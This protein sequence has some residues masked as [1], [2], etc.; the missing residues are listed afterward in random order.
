MANIR[1]NTESLQELLNMANN[2]PVAPDS[3]DATATAEYIIQDKTAYVN[4]KE[5]RGTMPIHSGGTIIPTSSIRTIVSAGTYIKNDLIVGDINFLPENIK[6]GINVLGTLGTLKDSF[7]DYVEGGVVVISNNDA[8][9][10]RTGTF[11]Y[12][13]IT[14]AN[15]PNCIDIQSSA[16]YNCSSL[17]AIGFPKCENISSM[18][19][20]SC[21][22]LSMVSFPKCTAI[23][24]YAFQSCTALTSAYFPKCITINGYSA[25]A[26]C[27]SLATVSFPMC[28]STGNY[29]FRSCTALTSAY[30]PECI[31]I[32]TYAF[33]NCSS[34]AT[35]SFPM[36][37][38]IAYSAFMSCKNI[39]KI[40]FP[41]CKT[42][43]ISAFTFCSSL[44][45]ASFSE[46]GSIASYAFYNCQKL[47]SL[48]LLASSVA[49]LTTYNAFVGTP[50][51]LSSYIGTFGSIYVPASLLASY[52]SATN[53]T[54]Y[55][56][57]FVG[58]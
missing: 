31:T 28:T 18:A 20:S 15:F 12:T 17:S 1:N 16:F 52:K 9:T 8:T 2:L 3:S 6:D 35:V 55:S 27:S 51:S 43:G 36:C 40:D 47:I 33:A 38:S 11:A 44:T 21:T 42:I 22:R 14:E 53:W 58:V 7:A 48:Y 34:L 50:M 30:F 19:F 26:Y 25:F 37:I 13:N 46:C 49:T 5:I 10:I 41:K 56:S 39:S 23:S 24:G 57:R 32:G 54:R 29:T 45:T 4:N